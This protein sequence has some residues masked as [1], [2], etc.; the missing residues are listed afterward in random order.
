M[1]KTLATDPADVAAV[2]NLEGI[3]LGPLLPDGRQSVILV[4]DDNFRTT[5]VTQFLAFAVRSERTR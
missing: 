5:E 4:S 1:S 3:T 2:D